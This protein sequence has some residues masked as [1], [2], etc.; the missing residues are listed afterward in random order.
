MISKDSVYLGSGYLQI[1]VH[2]KTVNRKITQ[3]KLGP[4]SSDIR[5]SQIVMLDIVKA[6]ERVSKTTQHSKHPNASH[7]SLFV[8]YKLGVLS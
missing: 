1:K 3:S 6:L 7:N 4:K 2:P 5:V 8:H